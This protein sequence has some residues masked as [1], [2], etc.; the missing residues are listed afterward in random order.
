LIASWGSSDWKTED[1]MWSQVRSNSQWWTSPEPSG[2][3]QNKSDA[4]FMCFLY[5][6][7]VFIWKSDFHLTIVTREMTK[8]AISA[9]VRIPRWW[10]DIQFNVL[11]GWWHP[12]QKCLSSLSS[13]AILR[14]FRLN[15]YPGY[16]AGHAGEH[17]LVP[18]P[19][20]QDSLGLAGLYNAAWRFPVSGTIL[21]DREFGR[22]TCADANWA[23]GVHFP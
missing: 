20:S 7:P 10:S 11:G 8:C 16:F 14:E 15:S 9:A 3:I 19:R 12:E 18:H 1:E 4:C 23:P 6:L 13:R 21:N 5:V 2:A 22:A 17:I